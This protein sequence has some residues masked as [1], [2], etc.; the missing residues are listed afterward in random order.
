[1]KID[2]PYGKT[3]LALDIPD[4]NLEN[5]IRGDTG[6]K[7]K[8]E[9]SEIIKSALSKPVNSKKLRDLAKGKKNATILISD[10]TRPS[11]SYK[12]LPYLIDE[13]NSGGADDIKVVCGL[14]IH[15]K[16]TP[17]EREK[18]AGSYA[19]SKVKLIDSDKSDCKLIGTT[20][21]NTPVE[22]FKEVLGSDL[23][24]ATGNIEYHYFA[25][26]S[27]GAKAVMPGISS[28]AAIANNHS[29]MLC[30]D[31]SSGNIV[32]NPV[33]ADIE[34]AGRMVGIDFIFNVILDDN[35]NIIDAV[36]GAN[37]NAFLEGVRRYDVFFRKDVSKKSDI[38]ITSPGGYPKDLNL[39][40]SHKALENV[41]EIVAPGGKILLIA[42]CSEGFG[43]DIFEEWMY[44]AKD[45]KLLKKKIEEKFVLGAHKAVAISKILSGI[46]VNL[47]SDFDREITGKIGFKKVENIQEFIDS[48]VKANENIKITVVPTGRLVKFK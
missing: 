41:K 9:E 12:F 25:G 13:L 39:Y 45:Y 40:Q 47:Y 5:I 38:I 17:Q 46:E 21:Y 34:E 24:I 10:I 14:G 36:S 2:I 22:I 20:S 30:D 37:N 27:G 26:Y 42:A 29:Y 28:Y 3:N 31:A 35:K 44:D 6:K 19:A 32:T 15:R 33:R 43:E 7:E 1:M 16:H 18:L 48:Q 23:L 4:N 11:P 8:T